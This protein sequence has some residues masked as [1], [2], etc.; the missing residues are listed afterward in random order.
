MLSYSLESFGPTCTLRLCPSVTCLRLRVESSNDHRFPSAQ[1]VDSHSIDV[2]D[3]FLHRKSIDE[4]QEPISYLC[5]TS[6]WS[7]AQKL[8]HKRMHI[9]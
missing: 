2:E 4:L 5:V 1:D 3:R 9:L 7:V 8:G 6:S